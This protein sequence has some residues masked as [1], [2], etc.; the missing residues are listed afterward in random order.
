[1]P[2]FI[3]ELN[4]VNI[5]CAMILHSCIGIECILALLAHTMPPFH[6]GTRPLA[7]AHGLGI[8]ME[9]IQPQFPQLP[10]LYHHKNVLYWYDMY[11]YFTYY[12][13]F[14]IIYYLFLLFILV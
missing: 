1:M 2:I 3:G 8:T 7:A 11:I 12:Y 14:I 6:C 4:N 5:I 10:F 9:T 13:L